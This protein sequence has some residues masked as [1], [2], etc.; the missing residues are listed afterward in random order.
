MGD[1]RALI[2]Y[3][4]LLRA[5]DTLDLD[6]HSRL[7]VHAAPDL[8]RHFAGGGESLLGA[9]LARSEALLMPAFT[10]TT[11]IVPPFGPENN[12]LAYGEDDAANLYAD[13]FAM[14]LPVDSQ[15][16]EL[17]EIFRAY[18]ESKRSTHPLLS[19][20]AAG[21]DESLE[22]QTLDHPLAPIDWMAEYD[23]DV[24]LI[25]LDQRA[26]FSLHLAESRAGRKTF[27]RWALS[28]A[29]VVTCT[30]MPGCS[31]GFNAIDERLS[32]EVRRTAIGPVAMHA[33]ALRDLLNIA[34]GWIHE[35]PR[36]LLCERPS[37]PYCSAVRADLRQAGD[38]NRELSTGGPE[39]EQE[40]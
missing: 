17:A 7:I 15:L 1:G 25:G 31:E 12:A 30:N 26:N 13:I 14:D 10:P 34:A 29:G 16:G 40:H 32:G 36:A 37:C 39:L 18:P 20:S 11:E 28:E 27:V 5:L 6:A 2:H 3:R 35:D 22:H 9:L 8:A 38:A 4:D 21:A 19:F 24:L 33:I 23:A